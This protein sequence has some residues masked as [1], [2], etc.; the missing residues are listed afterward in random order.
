M[1][2]SLNHIHT[3]IRWKQAF[4]EMHYRCDHPDCMHHAP[5][6]LL[7]GKKSVCAV[8]KVKELILK[9]SDFKLARPR[10][11]DC[12]ETAE[13]VARREFAAIAHQ[14]VTDPEDDQ[15]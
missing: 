13:A 2:K 15:Q 10:C 12:S 14:F 1:P 3:Y 5:V 6:S 11:E 8:C 4:G 9:S 7:R